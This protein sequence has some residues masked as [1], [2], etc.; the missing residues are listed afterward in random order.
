M[1]TGFLI[2][3]LL[4]RSELGKTAGLR[5]MGY[6]LK[7]M[8]FL[9]PFVAGF[10]AL[11]Y[12]LPDDVASRFSDLG[13]IA[14]A[15]LAGLYV[16]VWLWRRHRAGP[17][18]KR[19]PLSQRNKVLGSIGFLILALGIFEWFVGGDVEVLALVLGPFFALIGW[20][21]PPQIRANAVTFV[22][23][24]V[25]WNRIEGY[26]WESHEAEVLT[27]R[28]KGPFPLSMPLILAI[29]REMKD[30]VDRLLQQHLPA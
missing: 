19:L 9:I 7:M 23:R 20:A 24:V 15:A 25:P 3:Y 10:L 22:D 18:L 1:A 14:L 5:Q 6:S 13:G 16:V 30:D 17:V 11:I 28:P 2:G 27:V 8:L 29:P 21:T 4:L 12:F 26:S